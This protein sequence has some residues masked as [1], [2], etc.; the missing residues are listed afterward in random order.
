MQ[1][2]HYRAKAVAICEAMAECYELKAEIENEQQVCN[3][4]FSLWWLQRIRLINKEL[5][6]KLKRTCTY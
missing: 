5:Q 4:I 1:T 2:K 6:T 3:A